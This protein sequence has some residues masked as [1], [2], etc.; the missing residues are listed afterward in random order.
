MANARHVAKLREGVQAWNAWRAENPGAA[1]DLSDLNLPGG[2]RHF[3]PARGA[4]I[5]LRGVNLRRAV[6]AGADLAQARLDH[7][8]LSGANLKGANLAQADLAGTRLAGANLSGAWLGGVRN[9][10]QAAI[11]RAQGCKATVLPDGV[12]LPPAWV[13]GE[14]PAAPP[15]AKASEPAD[16]RPAPGRGD[17]HRILGVERKATA[18]EIRAAYLRLVKE[19]H[20]DGRP[21][22][23]VPEDAD[24][25]LKLIN[26]AYQELKGFGRQAEARRAEHRR[27]VR[28]VSA[29]F[30]AGVM[31]A[32]APAV[33]VLVAGLHYT[34]WLGAPDP[35]AV[36]SVAPA[37]TGDAPRPAATGVASDANEHAGR[38]EA[39][40]EARKL[41]TREAWERF[42]AAYP[43]GEAA[44]Q[45]RSAIAALERAEGRRL[46]EAAA[47]AEAERSGDKGALERFVASYP[48]SEN[49]PQARETIAAIAHA[50]ARRREEAAA[51][52]AAEK[53]GER[54]KLERFVAA[55]PDGGYTERARQAIATLE[56]AEAARRAEATAWAAAQED[57]TKEGL[58]RYVAAYPGGAHASQAGRALAALAAAQAQREADRAAWA[59]AERSG[60]K[61]ALSQYLKDFPAGSFAADARQRMAMIESEENDRDDTA[62][63]KAKQRNNKASYADYLATYPDGRRV[64]D[65]RR[66]LAELERGEMRPPTEPVKAAGTPPV[67]P[68]APEAAGG[69]RWPSADEPFVGADGRIRR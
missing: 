39:W 20:P 28:R 69:Q 36:S 22:G 51:W 55:Y 46:A 17:P 62:W 37:A 66:R 34:G 12:A 11:N 52:A 16:D 8:D 31:T 43:D 30:V 29:I 68:R 40:S 59:E 25:R 4:P 56:R 38:Q 53:T 63:F 19:L 27:R 9:L 13:G 54:E 61:T 23:A 15:P 47:W 48:D 32:T 24:E 64:T 14:E 1:P 35:G 60:A 67:R 18:R 7:A 65:A 57:G 33:L 21:P 2:A 44:A 50:E 26:D 10:T 3:E 49:V 42:I 58:E 45:A 5:D 6:L 41:G